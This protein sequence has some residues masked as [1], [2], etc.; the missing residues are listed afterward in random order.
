[1]INV[2]SF[3]T[4]RLAS[5]V[6]ISRARNVATPSP[7]AKAAI[8]TRLNLARS[9]I[10]APFCPLASPHPVDEPGRLLRRQ[11]T[12]ELG[13]ALELVAADGGPR[14]GAES[15]VDPA[16]VV[17]DVGKHGLDLAP[18][19]IGHL[20]LVHHDVLRR[21]LVGRGGRW[22]T[23]RGGGRGRRDRRRLTLL[24]RERRIPGGGDDLR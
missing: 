14:F 10:T 5:S 7:I 13:L 9:P 19:A 6:V 17:A 8:I 21:R 3:R 20:I 1:M 2:A 15:A 4:W 12:R 22:R 24:G 18:V 16:G 11:A 23:R